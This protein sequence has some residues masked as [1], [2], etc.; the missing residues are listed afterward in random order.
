MSLT[1]TPADI[2]RLRRWLS[3]QGANLP[4]IKVIE[5]GQGGRQAVASRRLPAG[6]LVLHLPRGLLMDVDAARGSRTGQALLGRHSEVSDTALLAA[7][8]LDVGRHGGIWSRYCQT[9]PTGF[10]EHPLFFSAEQMQELQGSYIVRVI[11]RHQARQR[12]EHMRLC[13]SQ[14]EALSFTQEAHALAWATVLTRRFD[15][16]LDSIKTMAMIPFADMPDHALEPNLQWGSE[17]SRGFFLTAAKDIEAGTPLTLRYW[18]Q[19]NGLTLATY[20][21][22]LEQNPHNVAELRFPEM[23]GIQ[24]PTSQAGDA[25]SV[26]RDGQRMFMVTARP[27]DARMQELLGYLQGVAGSL[28]GALTLLKA[29]CQ[30]RLAAFSTSQQEDQLLLKRPDLPL[31]LRFVVRVRHDEKA[32]LHAIEALNAKQIFGVAQSD[33]AQ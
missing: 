20:G 29:A 26:V 32:V 4:G 21:F 31:W 10:P 27:K 2:R 16:R 24:T 6:S 12:R 18:R 9:L 3:G 17:S 7:H 15:V 22:S 1:K 19:C 28:D 8:L 11:R 33:T 23:P 25:S 14:P 5:L 13:E 30:Q